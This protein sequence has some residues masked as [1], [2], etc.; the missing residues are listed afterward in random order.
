MGRKEKLS[1]LV[2]TVMVAI[3]PRLLAINIDMVLE[4]NIN[5]SSSNV[6]GEVSRDFK[7]LRILPV[8]VT[9]I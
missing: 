7:T 5:S 1:K 3:T 4:I 8:K 6:R 9:F 2:R